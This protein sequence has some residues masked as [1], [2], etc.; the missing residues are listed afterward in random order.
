MFTKS[1]RKANHVRRYS[2]KPTI[3]GWEVREE[4]DSQIV[5]QACYH[6]WHR[7]EH[8]RRV[9]VLQLTQLEREGWQE[10]AERC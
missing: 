3:E 7:V 8:A 4:R 9:F 10:V 6:D 1:I 2:I 5:R